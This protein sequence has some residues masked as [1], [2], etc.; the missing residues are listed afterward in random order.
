M[1]NLLVMFTFSVL[2][3]KFPSSAYLLQKVKVVCLSWIVVTRLNLICRLWWWCY[4]TLCAL[5][6]KH[7][8]WENL[9]QKINIVYRR[10]WFRWQCS[11]FLFLDGKYPFWANLVYILKIFRV[12][13]LNVANTNM[14]NLM[15]LII[16]LY[17]IR[18]TLLGKID[19]KLSKF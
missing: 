14:K 2:N 16:V 8:I 11:L 17:W 3:R 6:W 18:E 5:E 12:K 4:F 15:M 9:V 7:F 13:F 10:C 1:L 19:P